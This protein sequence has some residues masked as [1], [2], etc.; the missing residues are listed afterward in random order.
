MENQ[1]ISM[2]NGGSSAE[3]IYHLIKLFRAK[4]QLR[5]M[6][7]LLKGKHVSFIRIW[8]MNVG[9]CFQT[10]INM[11]SREEDQQHELLFEIHNLIWS[12]NETHVFNQVERKSDDQETATRLTFFATNRLI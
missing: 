2:Q 10:P 4:F 12:I 11:R 5:V 3:I 7:G 6:N 9:Y 1:Y 8:W